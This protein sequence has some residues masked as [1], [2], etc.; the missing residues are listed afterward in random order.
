MTHKKVTISDIAKAA[1][2]SK[3]TISRYLNRNYEYMSLDTRNNI[4][5][6]IAEYNYVPNNVART[7]KSKRSKLIG[8][9]VNNL[10]YQV[11]AQTVTGIND[12]CARSGYGTVVYC[13]EDDPVKEQQAIQ[14]CLNQQMDGMVIIPSMESSERYLELCR[15]GIPVMLCTRKLLDWPYGCAYVK[16]EEVIAQM[17]AHLKEQGFEKVRF[18]LDV[19]NFHKARMGK[20]FADASQRL[21]GMAPEE[22]VVLVGRETPKVPQALE[23]FLREYPKERKAVMAVN[24]HTLFLTLKTLEEWKVRI[25]EA[26]GVCGYDAQGWSE[27][28]YP[29]ITAIRQPMDQM[30][31]LAAKE[32]MASLQENR[33]TQHQYPLGCAVY[34]RKSTCIQHSGTN[35]KK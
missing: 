2:V 33:L 21:F 17:V 6:I 12:V 31:I 27:L 11:G 19:N 34:Y 29:G 28:V 25:P 20:A 26:L 4:E 23:R 8:V 1:G 3:T 35:R 13:T 7:L 14:L 30:G 24:T 16:H 5:R 10:R 9:V 22:S 18:L 15:Q 32:I